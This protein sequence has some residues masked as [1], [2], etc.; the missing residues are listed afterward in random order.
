MSRAKLKARLSK[1]ARGV[2]KRTEEKVAKALE[3]FK[4]SQKTEAYELV[5][6]GGGC[7]LHAVEAA[8]PAVPVGAWRT[9]CGWEFGRSQHVRVRG[10]AAEATCM[11]CRRL[12]RAQSPT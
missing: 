2:Q 4:A 7:R 3:D 8:H 9:V 12:G 5:R 1:F 11:K 6:S 10:L